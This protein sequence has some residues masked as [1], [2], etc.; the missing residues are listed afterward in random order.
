MIDLILEKKLGETSYSIEPARYFY[1]LEIDDTKQYIILPYYPEKHPTLSSYIYEG[2]DKWQN[3]QFLACKAIEEY[4][5]I[6]GFNTLQLNSNRS[7]KFEGYVNANPLLSSSTGY[8][9]VGFFRADK[10]LGLSFVLKN[11]KD[12]VESIP[13]GGKLDVKAVRLNT[14]SYK[15]PETTGSLTALDGMRFSPDVA[16][17]F[18][19]D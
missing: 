12:G 16:F 9:F 15:Q 17:N 1:D 2:S 7:T 5:T 19:N 13:G 3:A 11:L 4:N 8:A 14:T 6:V 18:Y 10:D